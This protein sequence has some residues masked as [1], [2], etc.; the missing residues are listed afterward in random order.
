MSRSPESSCEIRGGAGDPSYIEIFV[1][2]NI[3]ISACHSDVTPGTIAT[4][5]LFPE[6]LHGLK[7]QVTHRLHVLCFHFGARVMSSESRYG[8]TALCNRCDVQ[9]TH[10]FRLFASSI[11]LTATTAR[12]QGVLIRSVLV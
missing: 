1:H 8:G 4:S 5:F 6:D 2:C 3:V 7:W 9:Q 10:C 12:S 11:D